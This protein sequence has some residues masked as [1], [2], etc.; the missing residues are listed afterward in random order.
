MGGFLVDRHSRQSPC[1]RGDH[2][3]PKNLKTKESQGR[4]PRVL[5]ENLRGGTGP[6]DLRRSAPMRTVTSS[7]IENFVQP[8][9]PVTPHPRRPQLVR[10]VE[11]AG[12]HAAVSVE[13]N[14]PIA[15]G[16]ADPKTGNQGVD[17]NCLG[18]TLGWLASCATFSVPSIS[19]W[20]LAAHAASS[21]F[22]W[23][24]PEPWWNLEQTSSGAALT[25][26]P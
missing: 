15:G 17:R 13:A 21:R 22:H 14:V 26:R 12:A 16:P 23:S 5:F 8:P 3:I 11:A 6:E 24:V 19:H 9:Q 1:L 25:R 4:S 18:A 7:W 2:A 20:C 10:G